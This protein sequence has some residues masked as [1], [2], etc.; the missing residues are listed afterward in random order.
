MQ[1]SFLGFLIPSNT[2]ISKMLKASGASVLP[3]SKDGSAGPTL[4][5]VEVPK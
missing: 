1:S 2:D 4:S 5:M 3:R